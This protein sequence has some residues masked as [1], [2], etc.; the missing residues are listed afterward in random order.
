MVTTFTGSSYEFKLE[1]GVI[2]VTPEKVHDILGQFD[3]KPLKDI[4]AT[5]IAEKLVLAKRVDF[6]FKFNFLMLFTNV[7]GTADTMKA[8]VNLTVLRRIREDT[9]IAEFDWC[10]F[11][12]SCLQLNVVPNTI[13]GFYIGPLTFLILLYLDSTKFKRFFVIRLRL[14]IRNWT[15]T[16]MNKRHDLEIKEEVI[17][18]LE[19][20]WPWCESELQETERF[21][22]VGDNVIQTRTSFNSPTDKQSVCTLI[23]EKFKIISDEK[24]E[25]EDLMRKSNTQFPNDEYVRELYE[26]YGGVFKET[27]LLEEEQVHVDDFHPGDG[28]KIRTDVVGEKQTVV[29][30]TLR[31]FPG[32][33][34]TTEKHYRMRFDIGLR[35]VYS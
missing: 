12:H 9:N 29:D 14:A 1:K 30:V 6:M 35:L 20:H 22:E 5:N 4:R 2:R 8:I 31:K 26:K 23:E 11:I 24:A 25:L 32:Q 33:Y 34:F 17:G 21:Y 27:V 28:E 3:P 18:K 16:A 7:M 19:L 10:G 13:Y 15:T